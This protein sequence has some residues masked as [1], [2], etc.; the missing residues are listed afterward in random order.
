MRSDYT[1]QTAELLQILDELSPQHRQILLNLHDRGPSLL[2][3]I[4]VRMLSFP[5]EISHYV[6]E[7]RGRGLIHADGFS[8]GALGG[9]VYSLSRQGRVVVELMQSEATQPAPATKGLERN[10]PGVSSR[11]Q[12]MDL[13]QKLGDLAAQQ[14]DLEKASTFY[15]QALDIARTMN[16]D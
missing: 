14:G 1:P 16:G 6:R 10:L 7:L 13:L 11:Q 3:E 12:E 5:D 9:E 8:G 2:L 15:Q 4:A